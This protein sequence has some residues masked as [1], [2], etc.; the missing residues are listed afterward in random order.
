MTY[1]Y[2]SLNILILLD[3]VFE[4]RIK[5]REVSYATNVLSRPVF[6]SGREGN[7]EGGGER[8]APIYS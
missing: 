7:L 4:R 3:I 5:T 8:S 6:K 2:C 1:K